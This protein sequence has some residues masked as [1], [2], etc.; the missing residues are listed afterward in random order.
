MLDGNAAG[1][2]LGELYFLEVHE[3][4]KKLREC[5]I[6]SGQILLCQNIKVSD[7]GASCKIWVENHGEP[8]HV[9]VGSNIDDYCMLVYSGTPDGGGFIDPVWKEKALKFLGG[10]WRN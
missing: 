9:I 8:I 6:V 5:G 2:D 4:G 1:V 3:P 10:E 7:D